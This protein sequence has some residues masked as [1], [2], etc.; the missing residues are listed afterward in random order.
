MNEEDLKLLRQITKETVAETL[1]IEVW[2]AIFELVNAVEAGIT[3]F[4]HRLGVQ[5][6]VAPKV[7]WDPT[8]IEWV[9]VEGSNG[10]YERYPAEGE[11]AEANEDYRKMP[12]DLKAHVGKLTQDGYIYWFFATRQ[13]LEGRRQNPTC[14]ETCR[15]APKHNSRI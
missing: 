5:K 9:E 10:P 2:D 12:Q 7:S 1:D 11:K 15:N 13:R 4:K 3:S 14:Q 8:K 6:G